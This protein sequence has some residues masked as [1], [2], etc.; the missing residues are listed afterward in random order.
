MAWQL[1]FGSDFGLMSLFVIAFVVVMAI[2]LYG[3][4]KKHMEEDAKRAR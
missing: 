1:L 4:A 3:F 2:F